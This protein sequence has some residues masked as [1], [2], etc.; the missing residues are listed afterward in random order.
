MGSDAGKDVLEPGEGFDTNPL[1]GG[2]ETPQYRSRVAA[3]VAAEEHPVVASHRHATDV[4]FG[5]IIIDAQMAVCAVA[6]QRRPV[7]Q[8][9]AHRAAPPDSSAR[10]PPGSPA[11]SDAIYS[12]SARIPTGAG[13]AAPP[14]ST[15][16]LA[17]PPYTTEQ[18]GTTRF[19]PDESGRSPPVP[20]H[21]AVHLQRAA[22]NRFGV[23]RLRS[24]RRLFL[25]RHGAGTNPAGPHGGRPPG[26][27]PSVPPHHGRGPADGSALDRHA[28]DGVMDHRER[29][30][31]LSSTGGLRFSGACIHI[32]HRLR[33]RPRVGD[34]DRDVRLHGLLRHLLR[35]R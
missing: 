4:T 1:A 32:L 20:F 22:R 14:P 19:P 5:G 9:I 25:A 27:R 17:L 26:H 15:T 23:Y 28:G 11:S 33:R 18:C 7:L 16:A 35:R 2:R 31:Q 30:R 12:E 13:S 21:L 6:V 3:L 24:I 29:P 8:G 10:S 34:A